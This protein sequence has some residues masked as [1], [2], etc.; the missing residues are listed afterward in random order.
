MPL[1]GDKKRRCAHGT[2]DTG[3]DAGDGGRGPYR[4][5]MLSKPSGC[6]CA[7]RVANGKTTPTV[8]D[9]LSAAGFPLDVGH[10]GRLDLDTEGL[11]LFTDDGL[12]LRPLPLRPGPSLWLLH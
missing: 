6:V 1:P 2:D 9:A 8:Y 10:V 4:Y 12:L 3:E 11:L 5:L 7:R